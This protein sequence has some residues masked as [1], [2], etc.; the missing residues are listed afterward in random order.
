VEEQ[1]QLIPVMAKLLQFSPDE[2]KHI[3]LTRAHRAQAATQANQPAVPSAF[4]A[5]SSFIPRWT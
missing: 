1:E 5:L 2:L 3:K 4:E